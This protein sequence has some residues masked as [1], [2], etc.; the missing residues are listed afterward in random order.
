MAR[1]GRKKIIS[2]VNDVQTEISTTNTVLET[3]V[4]NSDET[5]IENVNNS[6]QDVLNDETQ[7]EETEQKNTV[8]DE[9]KTELYITIDEDNNTNEIEGVNVQEV[10]ISDKGA[11]LDGEDLDVLKGL[12]SSDD[13]KEE[14][15]QN[16]NNKIQMPFEVAKKRQTTREVF[17]SDMMGII[18][19]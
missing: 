6:T 13:K 18:Y 19:G 5:L 4:N 12:H 16:E 15:E 17:G 9:I 2:T 1:R 3:A 10:K 7:H 8:S 11:T 14:T